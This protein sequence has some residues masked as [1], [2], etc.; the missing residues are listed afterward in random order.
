MEG[1]VRRF[2][3]HVIRLLLVETTGDGACLV[4]SGTARRSH[5]VVLGLG[6]R[7]TMRSTPSRGSEE[8]NGG[9]ARVNATCTSCH[10]SNRVKSTFF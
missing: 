6:M 8:R 2:A 10:H 4:L 3:R 7:C 9:G 1:L 5:N